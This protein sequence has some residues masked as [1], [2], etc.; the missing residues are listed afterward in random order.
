M[1]SSPVLLNFFKVESANGPLELIQQYL[2]SFRVVQG[3]KTET[4]NE[5]RAIVLELEQVR[6]PKRTKHFF[7]V[8]QEGKGEY[9]N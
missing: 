5:H 9:Q 4:E 2:K 7:V 6:R 8:G 1:A 3:S